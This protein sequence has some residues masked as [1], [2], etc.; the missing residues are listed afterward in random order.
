MADVPAEI[1]LHTQYRWLNREADLMI[2]MVVVFRVHFT[3]ACY[4]SCE[5]V[6]RAIGSDHAHA[7]FGMRY[8][9]CTHACD[10]AYV[11]LFSSARKNNKDEAAK[12]ALAPPSYPTGPI[13]PRHRMPGARCRGARIR[14][15]HRAYVTGRGA[16]GHRTT[17][18]RRQW[19]DDALRFRWRGRSPAQ[20]RQQSRPNHSRHS[21]A[22][23]AQASLVRA[24]LP[25]RSML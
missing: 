5:S 20:R 10:L 18:A 7:A 17:R 4:V 22:P 15:R 1:V 8:A 12:S 14:A 2:E 25:H 3:S 13:I 6:R 11:V 21:T 9:E 16:R 19:E 23:V 24:L